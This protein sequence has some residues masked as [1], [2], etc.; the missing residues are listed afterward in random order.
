M[1]ERAEKN[2]EGEKRLGAAFNFMPFKSMRMMHERIFV[3]RIG[4]WEIERDEI[5]VRN[6]IKRGYVGYRT[7]T[8]RCSTVTH[9]KCSFSSSSGISRP[10]S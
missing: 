6:W 2:C 4:Q 7:V 9:Q 3:L 1:G 10:F 8:S 5:S